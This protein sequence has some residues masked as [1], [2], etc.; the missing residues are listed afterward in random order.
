MGNIVLF[1]SYGGKMEEFVPIEP[2]KVSIYVCGPTVYNHPH[3]GNMRPAIVFDV[4]RRLFLHDGYKV[5]YVSNYTDVDDKIINRAAELGISEKELTDSIIGEYRSLIDELGSMQPDAT[6]TPTAYMD[7]IIAYIGDLIASGHAYVSGG[8]VYFRVASIPHY[9][10]LSGNTVDSL[11][12]GARIEVNSD[13]ESPVDFAL[14]KQT[15]KGIRFDS[16]WGKGRPGWHSECCV[17]ID[18]LFKKEHGYID[19][20]GGG[21]DLKFPHH[22]NEIAQSRAHNGNPLA[23]YWLHNGFINIDEEK[24]SKSLGNVLLAKDVVAE[25]GAMPFRLMVLSAHYRAP[26]N[27]TVETIAEAKKNYERLQSCYR[28]LAI[29]LQIKGEDVENAPIVE[30]DDF[31]AAL[32]ADLNTPNALTAVYSTLKTANQQLRKSATPASELMQTFGKIRLYSQSLGLNVKYP[33]LG[34]QGQDLY[35]AYHKAKEE[36]DYAKADAIRKEIADLG[37]WMV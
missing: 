5:T 13:K 4:W 35:A 9:G 7:K 26:L 22:E 21:F 27:F 25:Y 3:I 36:K 23:R 6:P 17:M 15:S 10:E 12:S 1:N 32:R 11:L 30:D 19:I 24:M 33:H 20:H 29:S 34:K 8:D 16:P 18:S 31:M 37:F 14:W 2:G 28:S